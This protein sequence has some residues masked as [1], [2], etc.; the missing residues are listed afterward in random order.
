MVQFSPNEILTYATIAI[1][2]VIFVILLILQI[3][4]IFNIFSWVSEFFDLRKRKKQIDELE[5]VDKIRK[6]NL[7]N[8]PALI[9][10]KI[11]NLSHNLKLLAPS[12]D[13]QIIINNDSVFN[14]KMKKFIY[15]P[16]LSGIG[17]VLSE[18]SHDH[19]IKIP[20]QGSNRF[21]TKFSIPD[22]V[23]KHLEDCKRRANSGEHG[24][25]TWHFRCTAYFFAHAKGDFK[26]KTPI[27]YNKEWYEI[28]LPRK[29]AF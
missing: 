29:R 9:S 4:D 19:E 15:Q 23:A 12:V 5:E 20:Y 25:L 21:E 2:V 24:K 1:V 14:V 6:K 28:E 10:F 18:S 16:S 7:E 11:S 3:K 13:L 22:G 17:E 8:L 26:L 27:I